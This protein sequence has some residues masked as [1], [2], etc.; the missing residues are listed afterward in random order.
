MSSF[1]KKWEKQFKKISEG[2]SDFSL[3]CCEQDQ[4]FYANRK[5]IILPHSLVIFLSINNNTSIY[6]KYNNV[7]LSH[8]N[9]ETEST[10]TSQ[11]LIKQVENSISSIMLKSED[12]QID[13]E[14]L[15]DDDEIMIL[16]FMET[17]QFSETILFDSKCIEKYS[18]LIEYGSCT[19][20]KS[21]GIFQ[22]YIRNLNPTNYL[23]LVYASNKALLDF[24][25]ES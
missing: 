23:S 19:E 1:Q 8:S 25:M 4:S 11:L 22:S 9:L 24:D 6:G 18:N 7:N 17:K 12:L 14:D 5:K 2:V 13:T 3:V 20:R 16:L 10:P 15:Q 21:R